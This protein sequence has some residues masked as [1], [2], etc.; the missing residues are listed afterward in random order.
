MGQLP[1]ALAAYMAKKKAGNAPTASK[2]ATNF[3]GAGST[4]PFGLPMP[5]VPHQTMA[6]KRAAQLAGHRQVQQQVIAQAM[7]KGKK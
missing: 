7:R 6:K 2:G 5:V 4:N 3:N 1:A